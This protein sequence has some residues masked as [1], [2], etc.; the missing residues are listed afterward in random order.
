VNWV[1]LSPEWVDWLGRRGYWLALGGVAVVAL[2]VVN[3]RDVG[4][5]TGFMLFLFG[6]SAGG[7]GL[8]W[9]R[10]RGVWMLAVVALCAWLPLYAIMQLDAA[11]RGIGAPTPRALLICCD[12]ALALAVV[13]LQV[14][15]LVT[16]VRLNR[17]LF[18]RAN[19]ARHARRTSDF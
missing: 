4:F 8:S 11:K 10:E 1:Y 17:T 6:I 2:A 19:A 15:F 7:F 14:R 3:F 18:A 12:A 9:R 5:I 16:V 13:W